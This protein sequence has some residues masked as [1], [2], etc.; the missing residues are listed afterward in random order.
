MTYREPD[1][2]AE[3]DRL[4]EELRQLRSVSSRDTREFRGWVSYAATLGFG[5]SLIVS[6]ATAVSYGPWCMLG[7]PA[8]TAFAIAVPYL[9]RWWMDG[10]A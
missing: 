7:M 5:M 4:N 6:V 9:N 1:V 3:I 8:G 10:A 2:Q